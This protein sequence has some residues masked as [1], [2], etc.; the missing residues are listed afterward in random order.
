MRR[1]SVLL[2]AT[3]VLAAGCGFGPAPT[4]SIAVYDFGGELPT[5]AQAR[6]DASLALDEVSAPAWLHSSAIVYRLAYRDSAQVQPYSRARW[7]ASPSV[8]V[9]QRLRLALG[10]TAQRGVSAV[11]DSVRSDFVLRIELESFMQVVESPS[12]ARGIVRAR[13][14]L[15][16]TAGRDLRAQR[17]FEA[18]HPSPSVDA[19]G[20]V[21]ALRAA[22][23][24]VIVQLVE[25]T[26]R[27]TQA[28][29]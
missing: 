6:L 14:S 18:E 11:S 26:A 16:H 20:A 12:L 21:R 22:T 9:G 3:G 13:A 17:M 15:I 28:P 2:M 29:R 27:E 4:P 8:L 19:P 10:Q 1:R 25:W 5:R 23:D 7:A 24:A